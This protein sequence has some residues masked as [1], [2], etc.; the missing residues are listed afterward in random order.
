MFLRTLELKPKAKEKLEAAGLVH[1]NM[2]KAFMAA[3]WYLLKEADKGMLLS[4]VDTPMYVYKHSLR[5]Q[6]VE[7]IVFRY[8]MIGNHI[9]VHDVKIEP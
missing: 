9:L 2:E 4:G 5:F 6:T 3:K 8:S 7:H 1:P